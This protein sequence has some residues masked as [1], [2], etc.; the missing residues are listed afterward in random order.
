MNRVISS[1]GS[2]HLI[3]CTFPSIDVRSYISKRHDKLKI[4][5]KGTISIYR[6]SLKLQKFVNE[7]FD[8]YRNYSYNIREYEKYILR[9]Y[10]RFRF[11]LSS[12]V[13]WNKRKRWSAARVNV[14]KNNRATPLPFHYYSST[15]KDRDVAVALVEIFLLGPNK[16][17]LG[18]RSLLENVSFCAHACARPRATLYCAGQERHSSM[19]FSCFFLYWTASRR[20]L[21]VSKKRA[22][23]IHPSGVHEWRLE[24]F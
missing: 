9:G 7:S 3:N 19:R 24:W 8:A 17:C 10:P 16:D 15:R 18:T 14:A 11:R 6:L 21:F 1:N 12:L 23:I 2:A 20:F 13:Q 4:L 22:R 5:L